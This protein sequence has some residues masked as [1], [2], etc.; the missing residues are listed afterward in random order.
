MFQVKTRD[1][2]TT[3]WDP[4]KIESI[5]ESGI[6]NYDAGI[7]KLDVYLDLDGRKELLCKLIKITNQMTNL[8]TLNINFL[9]NYDGYH[10]PKDN[11]NVRKFTFNHRI[12]KKFTKRL[13]DV[14]ILVLSCP[15]LTSKKLR[16]LNCLKNLDMLTIDMSRFESI[17]KLELT[18]ITHLDISHTYLSDEHY[19]S[20]KRFQNLKCIGLNGYHEVVRKLPNLEKII[21]NYVYDKNEIE[22][23]FSYQVKYLE[24]Y[25]VANQEPIVIK[26]SILQSL[27]IDYFTKCEVWSIDP[28]TPLISLKMP[29]CK[30]FDKSILETHKLQQLHLDLYQDSWEK[31]ITLPSSIKRFYLNFNKPTSH[32]AL[33]LSNLVHLEYFHYANFT[34]LIDIQTGDN[35]F[36]KLTDYYLSHLGDYKES[37]HVLEYSKRRNRVLNW[38]YYNSYLTKLVLVFHGILPA[39]VIMWIFDKLPPRIEFLNMTYLYHPWKYD[40]NRSELYLFDDILK[41]TCIENAIKSIRRIMNK[42]NA[43]D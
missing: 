22:T 20:L 37:C 2:D 30:Y 31:T 29:N 39:Y 15:D 33:N 16:Y 40:E 4:N 36:N 35:N 34:Q 26:N 27:V 17:K 13:I 1:S 12:S 19:E 3:L 9:N 28:I 42:R 18:Q 7:R 23:V 32:K 11:I 5:L 10:I 6:D 24:I 8:D 21:L 41:I 38:G 43:R 25:M 14:K